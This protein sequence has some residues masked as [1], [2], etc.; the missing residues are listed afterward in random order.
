MMPSQSALNGE[1][2]SLADMLSEQRATTVAGVHYH[3]IPPVAAGGYHS[4]RRQQAA[5]QKHAHAVTPL[6]ARRDQSPAADSPSP[7]PA[8]TVPAATSKLGQPFNAVEREFHSQQHGALNAELRVAAEQAL[9]AWADR[10]VAVAIDTIDKSILRTRGSL[11]GATRAA[12]TQ[13]EDNFSCVAPHTEA[14]IDDLVNANIV[15]LAMPPRH[16]TEINDMPQIDPET[17]RYALADLATPRPLASSDRL[18]DPRDGAAGIAARMA[19]LTARRRQLEALDS[20]G[21]GDLTIVDA[22]ISLFELST[23]EPLAPA[24]ASLA[25]G[26]PILERLGNEARTDD[27]KRKELLA[28]VEG[29]ASTDQKESGSSPVARPTSTAAQNLVDCE[30]LERHE[31]ECLDL[32]VQQRAS[33]CDLLESVY[34]AAVESFIDGQARRLSVCGSVLDKFQSVAKVR[35][36]SIVA[37]V[38]SID[39]AKTALDDQLMRQ[40]DQYLARQRSGRAT[41]SQLDVDE[42]ALWN[43]IAAKLE[44]A[45]TLANKRRDIVRERMSDSEAFSQWQRTTVQRQRLMREYMQVL[46]KARRAAT[47]HVEC[48]NLARDY[49]RTL[50]RAIQQRDHRAELRDLRIEECRTLLESLGQFLHVAQDYAGRL[51]TRQEGQLRIARH[52]G[53]DSDLAVQTFDP[54]SRVLADMAQAAQAAVERSGF[55]IREVEDRIARG[56]KGSLP[57]Q[58]FLYGEFEAATAE[59]IEASSRPKRPASASSQPARPRD[60]TPSSPQGGMPEPTDAKTEDPENVNALTETAPPVGEEVLAA[61]PIAVEESTPSVL[62]IHCLATIDR[63]E[64]EATSNLRASSHLSREE[65]SIEEVLTLMRQ[66]KAE[67]KVKRE[68]EQRDQRERSERNKLKHSGGGTTSDNSYLDYY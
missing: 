51:S 38:G 5:Q 40:Q 57:A 32:A 11:T 44:Q 68:H 9:S 46:L 65:L 25:S 48:A 23:A 15:Q 43:D 7:A 22:L 1:E 66:A 50:V 37:D 56:S 29:V 2:R 36:D 64:R 54:R 30:G 53:M 26:T 45:R 47:I 13:Y 39:A 67:A 59:E 20:V 49:E 28:A 16:A 34:A 55:L 62:D 41:L 19:R 3:P 6:R 8:A 27:T 24:R 14:V 42:G 31:V 4:A 35:F 52:L 10:A 17:V 63:T 18:A 21:D 58:L 12:L 33:R 60:A 61:T